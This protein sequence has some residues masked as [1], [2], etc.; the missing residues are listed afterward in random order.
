MPEMAAAMIADGAKCQILSGLKGVVV[1]AAGSARR[2]AQTG[3]RLA[4][5]R[6]AMIRKPVAVP[7]QPFSAREEPYAAGVAAC[8]T[9]W[10]YP[11]FQ[12]V[13]KVAPGLAAGCAVVLKPSPLASPL[14]SPAAAAFPAAGGGRAARQRRGRR[15][16]AALC[17]C[18]AGVR[19][20]LVA[21]RAAR[22]PGAPRALRSTRAAAALLPRFVWARG[23]RGGG[24]G[25]GAIKVAERGGHGSGRWGSRRA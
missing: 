24:V 14:A 10:N 4:V 8:I 2:V 7:E 19:C 3:I 20:L 9:P 15:G 11:L 17:S 16:L 21:P 5:S 22:C 6:A 25:V 12:A 23:P 13:A 1:G 18:A